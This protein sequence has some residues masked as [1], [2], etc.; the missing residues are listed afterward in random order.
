LKQRIDSLTSENKHLHDTVDQLR[1][2]VDGG[3]E[4][5]AELRAH[6]DAK[7]EKE[8]EITAECERL[9]DENSTA[10]H[11]RRVMAKRVMKLQRGAAEL[12]E[13]LTTIE[14]SDGRIWEIPVQGA[15]APFR[16]LS[17][18]GTPI[19]SLVNLKGGV[20]KTTITANL[21]VA[22]A[23]CGWR[24]LVVDLDH[25]GT[26]SQLLLT[27]SEMDE[28]LRSRRLV[29][30]ALMDPVDGL[31][32]FNQTVVRVSRLS[33]VELFLVAADEELGDV[34]T[35]M[36][37][38]WLAQITKDDIRYRLRAILHSEKIAD[39]FDFILLDCPP[40]LTTA[41]V[42]ALA[43]SD[44]VLVPVLPDPISTAAVPRLLR[45]L[46]HLR[47]VACSELAVLG[48]VGN[49]A[50]YYGDMPVKSQ[51]NELVALEVSCAETWGAPLKFF[52]P[53]RVHDAA[54]QPLPSLDAKLRGPYLDL[55]HQINQELPSYARSRSSALLASARPSVG[56]IRS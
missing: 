54:T 41:C 16:A 32:K 1:K 8:L 35:A 52:R 50:K 30:Q 14:V 45:W 42:N 39:R 29:H 48:V 5:I 6:L 21:A 25:Q 24:V 26:L 31:A 20:G 40:R 7:N 33:E 37:Q 55:V 44:Y 51:K 38:R 4:R 28:L 13:Q 17:Q 23:N 46:K 11:Q 10:I 49:K 3:R 27:R 12:S 34:E 47:Q 36:S 53:F 2:D 15:A 18:R 19:L 43:A 56:S 22:M 9:K